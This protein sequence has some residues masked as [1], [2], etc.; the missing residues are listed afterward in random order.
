MMNKNNKQLN[1][2]RNKNNVN[3]VKNKSLFMKNSII[4]FT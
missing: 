3:N 4:V 1:Y 2:K